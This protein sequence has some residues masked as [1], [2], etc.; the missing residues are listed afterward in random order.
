METNHLPTEF[1]PGQLEILRA[2]VSTAQS[3]R[4]VP[5]GD[6]Q[7]LQVKLD[8]YLQV[9]RTADARTFARAS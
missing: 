4:P 8:G 9:V 1:T 6:L 3:K 5:S 7:N 2:L